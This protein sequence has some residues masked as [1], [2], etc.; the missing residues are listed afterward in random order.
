MGFSVA[1]L[2]TLVR[3]FFG[4][5]Y[6]LFGESVEEIL[7]S[8]RETEN[9]ATVR[10]TVDEARALL[11]QYPEEQQLE[12]AVAELADGEFAPAPW[13]YTARSFLEKVISA[14]E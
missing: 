8:Y 5:N 12:L 10:K 2:G 6:D 11:A 9:T 13:G 3:V 1:N 7:A 14:L 4:Q